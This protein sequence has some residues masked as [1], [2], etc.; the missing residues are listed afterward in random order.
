[1]EKRNIKSYLML[2]GSMLTFGTVGV[3]RRCIPISSGLL[4]FT[5]GVLGAG[6][7]CLYGFL[8]RGRRPRHRIEARELLMLVLVGALIGGNWMLLFESYNY[9]TVATATMCYYMQPTIVI[10]LSPLFFRERLTVSRLICAA[11]AV[12]G[13]FFISGSAD[14]GGI[15]AGD[16][17][18]IIF[19]LGAALLYSAIVILNKKIRVEDSN[20]KTAIELFSAAVVL[21]PYILLTNS[22]SDIHMNTTAIILTLVVGIL[23]TGIAYAMY[24]GSMSG[25]RAQSIA[26]LSYIDPVFALFLSAAVLH[27]RLTLL[28]VI[29]SVLIIGSA[30]V[31]ELLTGGA[32]GKRR[33]RQT[34][35]PAADSGA[36]GRAV[37]TGARE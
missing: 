8:R 24:F 5:R 21:L 13:M 34:E 14:G 18:G 2:I 35:C 23:H 4:A 28:G 37:R 19:G 6:F 33:K 11:T 1:M 26:L 22:F 25:L 27:E 36:N 29:G 9:T 17:R 7:L 31:S 10:L 15:G 32:E 12:A 30:F 3:F 20:E 16:M